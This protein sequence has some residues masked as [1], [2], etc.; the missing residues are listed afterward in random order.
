MVKVISILED[1]PDRMS[2]TPHP[3]S[4]LVGRNRERSEVR[5]LLLRDDVPLVTLTGPGG[6]GK[7]R[8]ALQVLAESGSEFGERVEFIPLSTLRDPSLVLPAIAQSLGLV[9]SGGTS[10]RVGLAKY[11]G[12]RDVLLV[13]DNFEQVVSAASDLAD[14]LAHCPRLKL[15]VTSRE[16]LRIEGEHDYPVHPLSLPKQSATIEEL[17]TADAAQLFIQRATAANADFTLEGD[18]ANAISQICI[19]LD[20]LPLAIELAAARVKVLT[21]QAILNRLVDRLTLLSR[22]GRDVPERLRSMRDAVAWSYDLLP[23]EERLV[24]RRLSVF[25]GGCTLESAASV[26]ARLE[27]NQPISESSL[28]EKSLLVRVDDSFGESRFRM[29]ETVRAF[30]L[31]QSKSHGEAEPMRAALATWLIEATAGAFEDPYGARPG[32]WSRFFDSEMDNARSALEWVLQN[33]NV[34]AASGLLLAVSR[35]CHIRANYSEGWSWCKRGLEQLDPLTDAEARARLLL[36]G[37]WQL[38]FDG[39]PEEAEAL[40]RSGLT[41]ALGSGIDYAVMRCR[42]VL[43][44]ILES[45]GSYNEAK[46]LFLL[47]LEDREADNFNNWHAFALNN[48]GHTEF[49]LGNIDEAASL[50]EQADAMFVREGV[51]LGH[52]QALLNLAKVARARGEMRKAEALFVESLEVHWELRD[53]RGMAG[54]LRGLGSVYVRSKRFPEAARAFGTAEALREES[55]TPLHQNNARFDAAVARTRNELGPDRFE[56]EWRLGRTAPIETTVRDAI[57]SNRHQT[58]TPS[59]TALTAREVEVLRHISAGRSNRQIG[60]ALFIS[61]RTAQTHV[62]HILTK[63]DVSTRAAAAARAS[64]LGIADSI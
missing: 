13:L 33:G 40:V 9:A 35:H 53:K 49:E 54:C 23:D 38:L 11:L 43:G 47:S 6:V 31:E 55:G 25:A 41:L 21:P 48:L 8:L 50:F 2:A 60:E 45:R 57:E 62:Q 30:A 5:A 46:E 16:T 39:K 51:G 24:F 56:R 12:D 22:D 63:L 42:Q 20:G 34:G 1:A 17:R 61:E 14:L 27:T 37:S 58:D 52:G 36:A 64:A 10:P 19:R 29:L 26:F 59:E 15:L 44:V 32:Y 28:V 3:R 4:T 18:S 7:T